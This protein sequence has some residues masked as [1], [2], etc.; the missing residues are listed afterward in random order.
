LGIRHPQVAVA[1]VVSAFKDIRNHKLLTL[2]ALIV[3][4]LVFW[5]LWGRLVQ[6]GVPFI[7]TATRGVVEALFKSL[8]AVES[9][10]E[11]GVVGSADFWSFV[12]SAGTVEN[13]AW[14]CYRAFTTLGV[15]IVGILTGWIVGRLHRRKVSMVLAHATTILVDWIILGLITPLSWLIAVLTLGIVL[16]GVLCASRR[17][18]EVAIYPRINKGT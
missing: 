12:R 8:F 7:D 18:P 1:I 11:G 15:S 2:R 3:G 9:L 13:V 16:G 5:F 4:W 10:F 14:F 17:A 6:Y